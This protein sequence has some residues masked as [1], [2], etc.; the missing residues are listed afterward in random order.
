MPG[1]SS[2]GGGAFPEAE[3]PTTLVAL[4]IGSCEAFLEALRRHDPPV[5]ARAHEGKVVLDVRTIADEE[6]EV[7][8]E[9]V[10]AAR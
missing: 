9:A 3:L 10:R 7:V 5:I 4:D 6:F 2:V 8:A 1:S